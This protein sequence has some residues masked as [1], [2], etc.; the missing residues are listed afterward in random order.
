MARCVCTCW[1]RFQWPFSSSSAA[2]HFSLKLFCFSFLNRYAW[3][4][5]GKV[6]TIYQFISLP[7]PLS[8]STGAGSFSHCFPL[9]SIL[10]SFSFFRQFLSSLVFPI[11]RLHLKG[12]VGCCTSRL[13]FFHSLGHLHQPFFH[14]ILIYYF[15]MWA[16]FTCIELLERQKP[17]WKIRNRF[18]RSSDDGGGR[19]SSRRSSGG[20]E[21][22]V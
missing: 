22:L 1:I 10:L 20:I 9:R 19:R 2:I 12:S 11:F 4:S 13:S 15:V 14:F 6:P 21:I 3:S 16:E 5:N 8:H 7:S 18:L 17:E